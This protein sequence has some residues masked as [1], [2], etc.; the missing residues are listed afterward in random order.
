MWSSPDSHSALRAAQR[1]IPNRTTCRAPAFT[2]NS[3]TAG[4]KKYPRYA[5]IR[6]F[7][8]GNSNVARPFNRKKCDSS[9]QVTSSVCGAAARRHNRSR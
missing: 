8:A 1:F 5:S 7:P 3:A 9:L 4:V 2:S 6:Y